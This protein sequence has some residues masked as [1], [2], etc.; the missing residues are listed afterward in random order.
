MT[1]WSML[2]ECVSQL[3]EPFR[4]SEIIGWFR[5]HH[6]EVNES[7]LAAHIQAATANAANRA[8]NNP[9]G[10]RRPLVRRVDHGL[11]VRAGQPGQPAIDD[12]QDVQ[13]SAGQTEPGQ[14]RDADVILIGCVRTKKADAS[15]AS[16]LFAS[17]LFEGRRRHAASSGRPWYILSAKFGLLAPGYVIGP[18]DVY[19]ADQDPGYRKAWGEFVT[20]QLEQHEHTLRGRRI[21]VHAGA[22][23]VDP[24]RGPLA[25]RGAVL[26]V[27]LAHLRQGEQLAWYDGH[28]AGDSPGPR[29]PAPP[30]GDA[31]EAGASEL[32]RLLSDR[33]RALSPQ[34]LHAGGH[35]DLM[36]PG[37]YSWWV[38]DQG[39]ADLSRGLGLPVPG[40]LIYAGQAGATRWPSGKR[41]QGTLWG[42]ISGMH[43]GG[44]AEFSTFR[45]TLA[46]ILR[47]VLGLD[48]EDDPKLSAWITTHLGVSTVPVPDPDRLAEAETAVL[49]LLDPP[50][51]LRG[52]PPTPIRVRLAELRRGRRADRAAPAPPGWG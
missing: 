36:V 15:P 52:R 3:D 30:P 19:L 38:D 43:L 2:E 10:T 21:E 42:R 41:T 5:R 31:I 28:R 44:A 22:A 35:H 48:T 45:R 25:G 9:L 24:L 23:Y 34:E 7:T 4:R 29:P 37:L 16:E 50:L 18:Y 47:P 40:G 13:L 20:A 12:D 32:A 33:S 39:A 8:Q 26:A 51:N 1:V 27:P 17:P 49:D 6:P 46:A 14:G 11:Y